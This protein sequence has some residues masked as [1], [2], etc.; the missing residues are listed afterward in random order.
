MCV[1]TE[2]ADREC[3][4]HSD[5][6]CML[7]MSSPSWLCGLPGSNGLTASSLITLTM[8]I[9]SA[10]RLEC[11]ANVGIQPS[12]EPARCTGQQ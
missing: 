2:A 6:K 10:Q 9:Q 7:R 8:E 12:R 1:K 11:K 5:R 4:P 3:A